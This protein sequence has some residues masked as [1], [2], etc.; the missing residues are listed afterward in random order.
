MP[1]KYR[2]GDYVVTHDF[3]RG[4]VVHTDSPKYAYSGHIIKVMLRSGKHQHYRPWLL[5][6]SGVEPTDEE[7][8]VF[9]QYMLEKS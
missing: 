2:V 4:F 5:S 3:R 6:L 8:A 7:C 9:A 1:V